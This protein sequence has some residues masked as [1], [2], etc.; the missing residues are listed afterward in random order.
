MFEYIKWITMGVIVY[1]VMTMMSP[2]YAETKSNPVVDTITSVG[3]S[4]KAGVVKEWDK[5]VAFQKKAWAYGGDNTWQLINAKETVKEHWRLN[6][7]A[8]DQQ[9]AQ[10]RQQL[11]GYWQT[12]ADALGSLAVGKDKQ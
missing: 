11:K 8:L 10:N 3:R 5:T 1:A 6:A 7:H 12:I 2:A 4:V 9:L